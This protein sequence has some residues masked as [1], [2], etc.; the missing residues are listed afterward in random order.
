MVDDENDD[1]T[2]WKVAEHRDQVRILEGARVSQGSV[3]STGLSN[4]LKLLE[5][6][7]NSASPK[8]FEDRSQPNYNSITTGA[9]QRNVDFESSAC[10]KGP[11]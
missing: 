3:K 4:W 11:F 2:T 7:G 9:W 1:Y 10:R 5:G 6:N 8:S